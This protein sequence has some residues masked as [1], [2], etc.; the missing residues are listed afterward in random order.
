MENVSMLGPYGIL[1]S[2]KSNEKCIHY[3]EFV[4]NDTWGLDGILI[5]N[6]LIDGF[7]LLCPSSSFKITHYMIATFVYDN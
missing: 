6:L 7:S 1:V 2:V 5:C 3:S 4:L